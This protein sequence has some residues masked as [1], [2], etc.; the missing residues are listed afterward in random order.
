MGLLVLDQDQ[1]LVSNGEVGEV[2]I[3]GPG[4]TKGYL[5]KQELTD[6]RYLYLD[7]RR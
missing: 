1:E 7:G 3:A 2:F 5:N 6:E 4:L